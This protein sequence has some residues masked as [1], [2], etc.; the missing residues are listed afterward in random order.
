M[1]TAISH[2]ERLRSRSAALDLT[3]ID[4]DDFTR[5]P[6]DEDSLRCIRYMHDV[7]HHTVCYLRDLLVTPLHRDPAI[8]TFLSIWAYEEHWHGEALG[9]VLQAH[10][11]P[12]NA[13]RVT[14]L[15]GT[16]GVV[17]RLRPIVS[18]LTSS[19]LPGATALHLAWGAVN[20][21]T[22]QAGYARLSELASHPTLSTLLRRIMRQEGRH[23][24][25]Y[26][27]EA[28]KL[29]SAH[30][31]A[32]QA[33]RLA[34]KRFWAPVGAGV[35]PPEEVGFLARFLFSEDA[36]AA[37]LKRIDRQIDRLPGLSGLHLTSRAVHVRGAG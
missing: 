14:S 25:F 34:L 8:T 2:H 37:A 22:T 27:H 11:E 29:L 21:W 35:M 33:T 31:L 30:P 10:G 9:E 1:S 19:I 23:I 32:R 24:D 7:E 36:G 3:G 13:D 5:Q 15:R 18:Q 26:S 4:F 16:L 12:G 6:L 17:D 20:E 28:T